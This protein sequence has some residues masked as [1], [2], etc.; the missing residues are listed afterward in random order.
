MRRECLRRLSVV[1][2]VLLAASCARRLAPVDIRAVSRVNDVPGIAR[3][4][5]YA[6]ALVWFE[7]D[8]GRAGIRVTSRDPA[9]ATIVASAEM[10]CHSAVG[11]GLRAM[12]LGFNQNY[13]RFVADFQAKDD[14]FRITF[15]DLYYYIKDIR[16]ESSSLAQ[17]PSSQT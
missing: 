14:R 3:D 8:H 5:A 2:A 7:N 15:S 11:A 6:R 4:V 1:S 9:T 17:G 16:Y 13:L 12:G 10:Q